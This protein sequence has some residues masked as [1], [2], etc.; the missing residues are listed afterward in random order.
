MTN[1][2]DQA[3]SGQYEALRDFEDKAAYVTKGFFGEEAQTVGDSLGHKLALLKKSTVK[4]LYIIATVYPRTIQALEIGEL[5]GFHR[6]TVFVHT[7]DL[8]EL[9]LIDQEILAGTE[10][11]NKPTHLYRLKPSIDREQVYRFFEAHVQKDSSLALA[12][13]QDQ[14][15]VVSVDGSKDDSSVSTELSESSSESAAS[16]AVINGENSGVEQKALDEEMTFEEKVAE[17]INGMA[18]EII[19]LRERV[20]DLE[21]RLHQK[22]RQAGQVDFSQAMNLLTKSGKSK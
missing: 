8:V 2:N 13:E 17:I 6:S 21:E 5:S 3:F 19:A 11:K 10:N 18:Q 12:L 9:E 16:G 14:K 1:I 22:S 4:T 15:E 20:S 7:R